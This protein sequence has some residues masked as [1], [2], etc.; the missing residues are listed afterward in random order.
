M[1]ESKCS[2]CGKDKRPKRKTCGA[3]LCQHEYHKIS[4]RS[5]WHK[6][7]KKITNKQIIKV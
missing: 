2:F 6:I 1:L 3:I 5:Y 7:Y 4:M